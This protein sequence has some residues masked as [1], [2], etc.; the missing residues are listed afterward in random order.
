MDYAIHPE[1]T[2]KDEFFVASMQQRIDNAFDEPAQTMRV[3]NLSRVDKYVFPLAKG[4]AVDNPYIVDV[5]HRELEDQDAKLVREPEPTVKQIE[6]GEVPQPSSA[7]AV[8]N[9]GWLGLL[10]H[11]DNQQSWYEYADA[12][13]NVKEIFGTFLNPLVSSAPNSIRPFRTTCYKMDRVWHVPEANLRV[14]P[15]DGD[16]TEGTLPCEVMTTIFSKEPLDLC[17]KPPEVLPGPQEEEGDMI[18]LR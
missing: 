4:F 3:I 12:H 6:D 9:P 5:V 8:Y 15:P 2:W 14:N 18:E 13:V 1:F 11:V 10:R 7:S 16:L 17:G